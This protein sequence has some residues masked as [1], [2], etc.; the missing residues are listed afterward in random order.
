MR[1]AT[2]LYALLGVLLAVCIAAFAVSRSEEKKEQ[3]KTSGEV[4]LAIPAD[5]V[6]ALSWTNN[7]G[8]FS[9]TKDEGWTYDGDSAFPVDGDK[10]GDLLAQFEAFS[11]AFSIDGAEDLSQYGLDDPVCTIRIT[12]GEQS[13]TVE[14]GGFSKMD[15][16]R[17]VSIGDGRVYLAAHDPLEEYDTALRDMIL[18]DT[19][20]DFD[21]AEEIAFSG[22][23]NYTILR[24]DEGKSICEDDVYFTGGKP[25]DSDNVDSYLRT[26][27]N[28]SLGDYVSYNAGD[29]ELAE[30]G[31][32]E[33]EL[34]VLVRWNDGEESGETGTLELFV[35]S[36]PDEAAAYAAAVEKGDEALPSVSHYVRVGDSRIVYPLTQSVYDKLTAVSYDT[37]RHQKLFTADF[38]TAT[39]ID[40]SLN[41]ET[42]TFTHAPAEG[43][44]DGDP[45]WAWQGDEIDIAD[46]KSTLRTLSA[47]GFT[48]EVPTG[49]EEISLT[50]HL[51]SE[52]FPTFTLTLYRYDGTSCLAAVDGTPVALVPR[53][54][55]VDLIE[56]V[57]GVTL[58]G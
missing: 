56:A 13:Y 12:A 18:D 40:I 47:S 5:S 23:E 26:L 50:V 45:V 52:D 38:D 15:E 24:D 48:D 2:K 30:Y 29:E 10:I 4:V 14:L 16:Q 22:A 39:G 17:Y 20:P 32:A 54:K 53:S 42:Y 27:R 33:P 25:L 1:K 3:I 28:L 11:A 43:D 46:L 8:T 19:I 37:L 21:T 31:L 34:T 35:S 6:T 9:F 49:Q 36:D 41:G 58:G 57:N 55:T 51:D 7:N 44:A